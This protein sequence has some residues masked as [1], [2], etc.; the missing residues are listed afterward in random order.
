M[1]VTVHPTCS[2]KITLLMDGTHNITQIAMPLYTLLVQDNFGVGQSVAFFCNR[3]DRGN[4]CYRPEVLLWRKLDYLQFDSRKCLT[5][6][7]ILLYSNDNTI[8]DVVFADKD[9]AKIAAI[10][11]QFPNATHLLCHFHVLRAV[12]R[13]LKSVGL[14]PCFQQEIYEVFREGLYADSTDKFF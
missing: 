13:H 10:K 7:F 3:R 6:W 9:C 5:Y 2:T 12:D 11:Q 4:D 1:F 14:S 8:T